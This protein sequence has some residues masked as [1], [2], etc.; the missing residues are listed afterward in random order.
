MNF[1]SEKKELAS[2]LFEETK[3]YDE[4]NRQAVS[5]LNA[6]YEKLSEN[7][8]GKVQSAKTINSQMQNLHLFDKNR[9]FEDMM[10]SVKPELPI[11]NINFH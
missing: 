8:Q 2:K 6:E 4:K 10:S 9:Y 11:L 7:F 3:S 1:F 5:R